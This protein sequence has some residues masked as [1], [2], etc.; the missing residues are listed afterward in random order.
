MAR[1][2]PFGNE[3]AMISQQGLRLARRKGTAVA[4]PALRNRRILVVDDEFL[5]AMDLEMALQDG[6]QPFQS[7][8]ILLFA[9]IL[10]AS[11]CRDESQWSCKSP[12]VTN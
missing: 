9:V 5:I 4:A 8:R 2:L 1:L 11:T 10:P 7:R 6:S 12:W 3:H